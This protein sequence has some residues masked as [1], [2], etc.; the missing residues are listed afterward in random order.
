MRTTLSTLAALSVFAQS[1]ASQE[2][3]AEVRRLYQSAVAAADSS[4]LRRAIAI[5]DSLLQQDSTVIDALWNLGIWH[6]TLDEPQEALAAWL[7]Y[8]ARDST[9]WHVEAKLIQTYQA[10]GDLPRRD[11]ALAGLLTH[12]AHSG[13]PEF[14]KAASFC[15]EQGS[16]EGRRVMAFQTFE[17]Q[18]DRMVFVTFYLIDSEGRDTARISLGSYDFTTSIAREAGEIGP[19]DRMY[20]LDYYAGRF[21]ATYGFFRVQPSYDE[22]RTLVAS[23]LRGDLAPVSSSRLPPEG[24]RLTSACS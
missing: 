21:H 13:D 4:D 5:T 15:R 16:I 10:L 6:G 14:Q 2:P 3:S 8:R 17:P 23:I 9:D 7:A 19:G 18:G 24:R 22:L 12:R 11:S 1:V 20:H